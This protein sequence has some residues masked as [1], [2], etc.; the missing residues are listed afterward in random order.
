M[1]RIIMISSLTALLAACGTP[2]PSE[3]AWTRARLACADVGIDPGS[4]GYGQ[5]VADLDESLWD[6]QRPVN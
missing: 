2:S 4:A 1:S 3:T 5:C 6:E